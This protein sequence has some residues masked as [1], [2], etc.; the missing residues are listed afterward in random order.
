MSAR[1]MSGANWTAELGDETD[2]VRATL[3]AMT[4]RRFMERLWAREPDLWKPAGSDQSEI[5]DRLGLLDVAETMRG[6]IDSLHQFA[7]QARADGFRKALLLGMGGSSLGP[8]VLRAVLGVAPGSLDLRVLDSTHPDSV[9]AAR[10]WI[11]DPAD[12]LFLVS[13]K[14]GGTIEVMSF[15][16]YFHDLV[17]GRDPERAGRHFVAITD[18]GTSL[19]RL[20]HEQN[21]RHA[22]I[23]PPDIGGR[24]SVLSFFGLAPAALL[25]VDLERLLDGAIAMQRACGPEGPAGD[26]PGA[27][28]GAI[29]GELA[30][31]GRDKL[32]LIASPDLAPF[33]AWVEQLIAEST[34]KEEAGILPV[35]GE[36]IGPPA[37]YGSDRLFVQLRLA[38]DSSQDEAVRELALA[39]HP[40]ARL[41]WQGLYDLG[42]EFFRWEMA[43]AVAGALLGINAFDQPNVQE[44]KDFTS[45]ILKETQRS[46]SLPDAPVSQASDATAALRELLSEVGPGQYIALNAYLPMGL[47]AETVLQRLRVLLRDR[48]HVA[49]TVGFGPRFLH[50]TGQLHKGGPA[51]GAFIQI[52]SE[53]GEDVPVPGQPYTF[54]TLIAA[55]ALGDWQALD[56]RG[57]RVIRVQLPADLRS[58]LR[59]LEAAV[60]EIVK[61]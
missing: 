50:S 2:R 35:D 28:L 17:A 18:P 36:P 15:Y 11:G 20:A 25:G 51:G 40:V 49:T 56:N 47:R 12:T 44:S 33:G 39:G 30:R 45:R 13:S 43:T 29:L 61:G 5:D 57:R 8:E 37:V 54:G 4:D 55:Q 14:S 22:F 34:G 31:R 32:T 42:A 48:Y 10:D 27:A 19:E 9:R 41:D 21:F 53:T 60:E 58:G 24:Y 38:G 46:G 23:N 6:Q 52:I 7:D 16:H 3:S 59:Q 26:N 1:S